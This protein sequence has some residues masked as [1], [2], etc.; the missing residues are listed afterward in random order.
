MKKLKDNK[1]EILILSLLLSVGISINPLPAQAA[2]GPSG[3]VVNSPAV[4]KSLTL[5]EFLSLPKAKQRQFEGSFISC[6]NV[7]GQKQCKPVSV[8]DGL[9]NDMQ[10]DELRYLD[11]YKQIEEGNT[12]GEIEKLEERQ[13]ILKQLAAEP[14][15][16]NY[17]A[18]FSAS[19][20]STLVMHP[21]DTVKTRLM[22]KKKSSPDNIS[23]LPPSSTSLSS[24]TLLSSTS[25]DDEPN[26]DIGSLYEG[27][28]ANMLKE[29]PASAL[30][31]GLYESAMV[32]LSQFGFFQEY[33][34]IS[35]LL[36]G[37]IGELVGSMIRAPAEAVKTRL[38]TGNRTF[39]EAVS[40]TFGPAG[41]KN[42]LT[43]WSS[44][45]FR[46]VPAGAIQIALFEL[47][48]TLIVDNPNNDFDVNTLLSEA[49]IGGFG[50]GFA[51]FLTN[52]SDVV[53]TKIISGG[54]KASAKEVF[55]EVLAE[56][57]LLGFLK[58]WK[59]RTA[60]WS[61]AIGIFLSVYCSLRQYS[62]QFFLM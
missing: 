2:Y 28:F 48:K 43:A 10:K 55:D 39:P 50:G 51:A 8:I 11:L 62:L 60:Y 17:A 7:K 5:E 19:C 35:Y 12:P 53:T 49:L 56:E 1:L 14:D 44:S 34:L 20:V 23:P 45:I 57:G 31:L 16:V 40:D 61:L 25:P 52:P 38:Q 18:G 41:I 37:A 24:A 47:I 36:A 58:G 13:R 3:A 15:W 29:A 42:T 9:L 54:G 46:D 27:L 6:T 22:S 26:F 21:L 32:F 59:Q 33:P 4:V 30:Y